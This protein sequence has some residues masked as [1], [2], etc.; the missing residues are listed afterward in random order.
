[1]QIANHKMKYCKFLSIIVEKIN[2]KNSKT[3][4]YSPIN[5]IYRMKKKLSYTIE[6]ETQSNRTVMTKQGKQIKNK[7]ESQPMRR[8]FLGYSKVL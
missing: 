8:A 6:E 2:N 5:N 3:V 7:L 1:M 4:N